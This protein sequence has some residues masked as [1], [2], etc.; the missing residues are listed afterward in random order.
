MDA[1]IKTTYNCNHD[2]QVAYPLSL[3]LVLAILDLYVFTEVKMS[4]PGNVYKQTGSL[5]SS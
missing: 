2:Q 1:V 3:Y 4:N 5:F